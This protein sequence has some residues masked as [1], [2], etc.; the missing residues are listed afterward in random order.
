MT[1]KRISAEVLRTLCAAIFTA[2]GCA[3]DEAATITASLVQ[4]NLYGH[5][6]H[7]VG[8]VPTYLANLRHGLARAG[9]TPTIAT[10]TGA[11]VALDGNRGF[12]QTIGAEAMRIAIAR[13]GE[14]GV[15]IAGLSNTHH[16]GRIGQWAEQCAQAG[17]ASVHFVNVLST[18]LVAP[19]GGTAARLS[20]NPFCVGV[21]HAPHPLVLDYAT[22]AIA[23]GKVRVAFEEGRRAPQGVLIDA[24]G[25]P[26]DDPG[27]LIPERV[28][29]L[30]PFAEHK[31][32]AL[33][34]MCELLGG[35]LSGGR[36]Q[37]RTLVPSPMRNNMLSIVFA[38]D[39]LCSRDA[40]AQ[41]VQ[42]L[43]A[44]LRSSPLA[45]GAERIMLPGEPERE[46]AREREANGIPLPA[47]VAG[48]LAACARE[49]G[50]DVPAQLED[51]SR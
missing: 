33:A 14:H 21:P 8:L 34:V 26:T 12:G 23:Y 10:D 43:A 17:F 24:N 7:G 1:T 9:R 39:R 44:W 49:L 40:L 41:Q 20:T 25:E 32:Y 5:D 28:G 50:V 29:A 19:W 31:G 46:T 18:P 2:A 27:V 22:S 45:P 51:A 47:S 37:D 4:T 36:V 3:R 48:D 38:P 13:A 35:A 16:L 11:L 42:S 6:S 30:L 15:A